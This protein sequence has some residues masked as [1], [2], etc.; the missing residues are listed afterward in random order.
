MILGRKSKKFRSTIGRRI[1][2]AE[3]LKMLLLFYK[4]MA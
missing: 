4:S 2:M 3:I 1:L